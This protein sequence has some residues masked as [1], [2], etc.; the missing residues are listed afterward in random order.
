MSHPIC[1]N[2]SIIYIT[3]ISNRSRNVI[4]FDLGDSDRKKCSREIVTNKC[5]GKRDKT[6]QTQKKEK[7]KLLSQQIALIEISIIE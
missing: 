6:N 1:S 5:N 4:V 7:M 2:Q 3:T